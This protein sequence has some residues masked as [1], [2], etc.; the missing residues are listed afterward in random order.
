MHYL[1]LKCHGL[2]IASANLRG[3]F[4]ISV[5]TESRLMKSPSQTVGLDLQSLQDEADICQMLPL[6]VT[7]YGSFEQELIWGW[8]KKKKKFV[9]HLLS[10]KLRGGKGGWEERKRNGKTVL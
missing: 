2:N 6:F 10:E 3:F 1:P 8:E 7:L 5:L 4:S 9:S